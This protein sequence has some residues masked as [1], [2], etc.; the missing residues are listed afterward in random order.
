MECTFRLTT[1]EHNSVSKGVEIN[2][3]R[4]ISSRKLIVLEARSMPFRTLTVTQQLDGRDNSFGCI[5]K[6]LINMQVRLRGLIDFPY[7][8][9]NN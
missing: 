2:F 7:I 5:C 1:E 6:R 8:D 4:L 3:V 9:K